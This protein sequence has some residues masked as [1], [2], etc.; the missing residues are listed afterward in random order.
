MTLKYKYLLKNNLFNIFYIKSKFAINLNMI[1]YNR[2]IIF[3]I[4]NFY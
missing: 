2:K 1:K 3:I 4:K